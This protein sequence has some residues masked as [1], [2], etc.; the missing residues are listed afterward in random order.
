MKIK[1]EGRSYDTDLSTLLHTYYE[2]TLKI[3]T[4]NYLQYLQGK[5]SLQIKVTY[6]PGNDAKNLL[7]KF[8]Y[9]CKCTNLL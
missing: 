4:Q 2:N 1:R 3:Y 5:V 9:T 8:Y 7:Y 6:L